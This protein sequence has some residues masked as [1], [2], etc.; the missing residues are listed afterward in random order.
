MKQQ[1]QRLV[2]LC[3]L[4]LTGPAW[5]ADAEPDAELIEFL[6]SWAEE[7]E[8]WEEFFDSVPQE[9]LDD[10]EDEKSDGR[11]TDSDSD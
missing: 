1:R 11:S 4:A 3:G 6:G 2:L 9:L 8:D 7:T 10:V 5:A